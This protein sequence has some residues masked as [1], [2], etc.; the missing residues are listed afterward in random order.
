MEFLPELDSTESPHA[1]DVDIPTPS[2]TRIPSFSTVIEPSSSSFMLEAFSI[3]PEDIEISSP[4]IDNPVVIIPPDH[5]CL[6]EGP[7]SEEPRERTEEEW[8][9]LLRYVD[10]VTEQREQLGISA[11]ENLARLAGYGAVDFLSYQ[12]HQQCRDVLNYLGLLNVTRTSSSVAYFYVLERETAYLAHLRS[13]WP[14]YSCNHFLTGSIVDGLRAPPIY[15]INSADVEIVRARPEADYLIVLNSLMIISSSWLIEST[16]YPAYV[17]VEPPSD[18]QHAWEQYAA[19]S[20]REYLYNE[21]SFERGETPT[22]SVNPADNQIYF[23]ARQ[24]LKDFVYQLSYGMTRDI[25]LREFGSC[26]PRC[27]ASRVLRIGTHGPAMFAEYQ[28]GYTSVDYVLA[29]ECPFWPPAAQKWATRKRNWPPLADVKIIVENGCHLVPLAP[30]ISHKDLCTFWRYS[31]SVAENIIMFRLEQDLPIAKQCIRFVKMLR[32]AYF[33][34]PE[35]LSSY[36]I[37][38]IV[39]WT[40]EKLSMHT[41]AEESIVMCVLQI[42]DSITHCLVQGQCPNYFIL[43]CNLFQNI[44]RDVLRTTARQISKIRRNPKKY[45]QLGDTPGIY[46][47]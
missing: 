15:P 4:T 33:D 42:L 40:V 41:W 32:K 11:L 44:P 12:S 3:P 34:F 7:F 38:T 9:E 21:P 29:V 17:Q 16:E 31:F 5:T 30:N 18:V 1:V 28:L 24:M 45:F 37:K 6:I 27:E 25:S 35:I 39:L 36:H 26:R 22:V 2:T 8:E 14:W 47:I 19:T 13:M 46:F 20:G 10:Q 23:N 43:E